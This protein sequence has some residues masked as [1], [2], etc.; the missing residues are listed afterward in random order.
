MQ[1]NGHDFYEI[2]ITVIWHLILVCDSKSCCTNN[3]QLLRSL[4]LYYLLVNMPIYHVEK[5]CKTILTV[6]LPKTLKRLPLSMSIFYTVN[7][8]LVF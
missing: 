5:Y 1:Y 6:R 4:L 3:D 7:Y 8:C 2:K